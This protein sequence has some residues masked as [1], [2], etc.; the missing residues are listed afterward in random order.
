MEDWAQSDQLHGLNTTLEVSNWP[1]PK[2]N[3]V[4]VLSMYLKYHRSRAGRDYYRQENRL[5]EVK[6]QTG[7]KIKSSVSKATCSFQC[8]TLGKKDRE[9]QTHRHTHPQVKSRTGFSLKSS[10]QRA[11][12]LSSASPFRRTTGRGRGTHTHGLG[13]THTHLKRGGDY[14]FHF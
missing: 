4:R 7:F 12:V 10:P 11:C 14:T 5:I 2:G 1:D 8:I 6:S 9:G 3:R 13:H